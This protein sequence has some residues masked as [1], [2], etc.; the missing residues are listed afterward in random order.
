MNKAEQTKGHIRH[1]MLQLPMLLRQMKRY[2]AEVEKKK[3]CFCS[4]VIFFMNIFK[5]FFVGTNMGLRGRYGGI[6]K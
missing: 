6:G 1:G 2:Y 5:I 3:E 4:L